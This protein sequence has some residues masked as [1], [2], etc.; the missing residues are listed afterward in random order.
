M[1]W[2]VNCASGYIAAG[3]RMTGEKSWDTRHTW[4]ELLDA[5]CIEQ[6]HL[7]NLNLAERLCS[8]SGNRSHA[9]FD[10]ALKN[11]HNWRQG[12]HLPQRRNFLLLTR[13]LGV[14][15]DQALRA[16]WNG[17]YAQA[18]SALP[19]MA[20]LAS[21]PDGTPANAFRPKQARRP[22]VLGGG[23]IAAALV[24]L[25]AYFQWPGRDETIADPG[26]TFAGIQADY[27]RTVTAKVG[28]ALIIHGARG[29]NCGPAPEW[30]V[31]RRHLPEL[32][33]G[34]LADGG[35][36]TRFSRQCGGRVPARAILFT[37]TTPGTEQTSL[38]G[39]PIT[40]TVQE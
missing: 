20:P 14:D 26:T 29:N 23:L 2:R 18:R 30:E 27:V 36:G 32:T 19:V 8:A 10:T 1:T 37:A 33:T 17:L 38:Y 3:V 5:L 21:A 40:I 9:A 31:A 12:V 7:D 28:D 39:D 35:V 6:G 15:R 13:L 16:H 22:L 4:H 25:F 11:L 24:G 34:T